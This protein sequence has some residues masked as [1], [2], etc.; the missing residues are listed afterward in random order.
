MA[1]TITI[2]SPKDVAKSL[3][4]RVHNTAKAA[5]L[6]VLSGVKRAA[7]AVSDKADALNEKI[8]EHA[9]KSL[10]Q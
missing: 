4:T 6:T 2:P 7:Y 1:L 5:E 10:T 8:D 9:N 3:K